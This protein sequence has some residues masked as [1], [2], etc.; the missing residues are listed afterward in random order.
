MNFTP[1]FHNDKVQLIHKVPINSL[2]QLG[3][4]KLGVDFIR[5]KLKQNL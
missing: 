5:K 2:R 1:T 3:K 4:P